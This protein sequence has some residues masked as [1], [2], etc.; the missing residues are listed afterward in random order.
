MENFGDISTV[1]GSS[2]DE[3]SSEG[4]L[5]SFGAEGR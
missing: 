5:G 3:E 4:N 2:E 1:E